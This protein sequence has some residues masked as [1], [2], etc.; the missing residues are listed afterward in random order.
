MFA[1]LVPHTPRLVLTVV[2]SGA[3]L[4][5]AQPLADAGADAG[6]R[7]AAAV[8]RPSNGNIIRQAPE[9]V[10][11]RNGAYRFS[12]TGFDATI[13]TDGTVRMRDKFVGSRLA[14][15]R[16]AI[17]EHDWVVTFWQIKWDLFAW[18]ERVRGNDPYRSERRWFL[19]GTHDLREQLATR[20]AIASVRAALHAIWTR[21]GLSFAE[22]R[23]LMFA[24]W[25]DTTEDEFGSVGRA[26]II[27]YVRQYCPRDGTTAFTD[28]ELRALNATRRSRSV[29]E[30]YAEDVQ[31]AP[32]LPA[33]PSPGAGTP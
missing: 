4:A 17:N 6:L 27:A 22:R 12:G 31:P 2:L 9:L 3:S 1:R 5:S 33:A 15:R 16:H 26:E 20:S 19:A 14:L 23:R 28:E 25:D 30:P 10:R 13:E 8:D 29:F 21:A 32:L 18:L 7:S 11:Q 24:L